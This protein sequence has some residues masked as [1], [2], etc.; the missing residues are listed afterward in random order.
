MN[1]T[2]E[3]TTEK[4]RFRA[5]PQNEDVRTNVPQIN[6]QRIPVQATHRPLAPVVL[7]GSSI[8]GR[9]VGVTSG[10]RPQ[11][12]HFAKTGALVNT[13]MSVGSGN[14]FRAAETVSAFA[15]LDAL[16][17]DE[18][19]IQAELANLR[20][21]SA[22]P[23]KDRLAARL[24]Q[25]LAAYKEDT[26]GR[27]FSVDS[28]RGLIVF[29]ENARFLRYPSVTLTRNGDIYASWKQGKDHVFS[30]QFLQTQQVRFVVFRPNVHSVGQFD[31]LSGLTTPQSLPSMIS[32]LNVSDWAAE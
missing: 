10:L 27:V 6:S 23:Y 5:V 16:R 28:L 30:A 20:H 31:Q 21:A 11:I 7:R 25:L 1:S 4:Q 2:A 32:H 26:D 14:S 8:V 9:V 15:E 29:L 22:I 13:P 24:D 17:A 3:Y 12:L 18:S 19:T